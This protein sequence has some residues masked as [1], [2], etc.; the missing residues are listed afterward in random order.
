MAISVLFGVVAYSVN[1]DSQGS[2]SKADKPV[3]IV[4]LDVYKSKTCGCCEGW[5]EHIEAS[6]FQANIHHPFDL[7]GVKVANGI[8][9][10]YA[11]CHTA[12]S[13][14][15][16]VFEGHIPAVI[17]KKFLAN[18]PKDAIGLAVPGMPL[19]SPGME[20]GDRFSPY[21]VLVLNSD[22]TSRVFA[23]VRTAKEQYE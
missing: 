15:G 7:N 5:I 4:I 1:A 23:E 18:P 10:G 19:G 9:P 14:N 12:I 13:D 8:K 20:V 2:T 3:E 11:S 16:Y 6:N 17:M 21:Q 22:G